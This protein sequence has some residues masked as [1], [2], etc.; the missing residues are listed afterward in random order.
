M[1]LSVFSIGTQVFAEQRDV[2]AQDDFFEMPIEDL[3]N[4]EVTTASKRTG[5]IQ[6]APS[7]MTVVTSADIK[8]AGYRNLEEALQRVVGFFPKTSK[9]WDIV[10]SRGI[11]ADMN[12]QYLFLIDGHNINSVNGWGAREQHILPLLSYVDRIEIIRGPGS[13]LWGSDAALG[14][15]NIITKEGG[16]IDGVQLSGAYSSEDHQNSTNVLVGK[17]FEKGSYMVSTTY[18]D[19]DGYGERGGSPNWLH[20]SSSQEKIT[21]RNWEDFNPSWEIYGKVKTGPWGLIAR[22]LHWNNVFRDSP[23]ETR[24]DRIYDNTFVEISHL[25]ELGDVTSLETKFF[26]DHI[27][28][29][30]IPVG[31]EAG[32]RRVYREEGFGGEVMLSTILGQK[33]N[34][35]LGTRFVSTEVGPNKNYKNYNP[36]TQE[37]ESVSIYTDSGTDKTLAVY[38]EDH[39]QFT[40][41]LRLIGGIR[42]DDNNFREDKAKFL[43][44][45]GA[46]YALNDNWTAKYLYNSGYIRP[47]VSQSKRISATKTNA[48]KGQAINSHDV[49][50]AYSGEKTSFSVTGYYLHVKDYITYVSGYTN[51]SDGDSKGIEF[52]FRRKLSDSLSLYGNYALGEAKLY[53]V[54]SDTTPDLVSSSGEWNGMPHHLFNLGLDWQ[55]KDNLFFNLHARSWNDASVYAWDTSINDNRFYTFQGGYYLDANLLCTNVRGLPLDISVYCTNLLDSKG[56]EPLYERGWLLQRSRSIGVNVSY[57]F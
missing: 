47:A 18:F 27:F 1:L 50:L 44:R 46:I 4:I 25:K 23:D 48:S 22:H 32:T 35:V 7:I 31:S 15:I 52:E 5:K 54:D 24:T 53:K 8:R 19:S 3:M 10:A 40:D 9:D 49:Q 42:F 56:K 45:F 29:D 55:I 20:S 39:F 2:N 14:I 57:R 13:T 26:T 37:S 36:V 38:A 6:Y 43:P 16:Q 41:K 12:H 51:I 28:K 33:H 34:I 17:E 21:W 11:D 30:R